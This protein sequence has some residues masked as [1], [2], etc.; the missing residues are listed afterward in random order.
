MSIR[1]NQKTDY[2]QLFASVGGNGS[3]NNSINFG[4]NLSDYASIKSGSY[5]K[6]MKAYYKKVDSSDIKAGDS[7]SSSIVK[8]SDKYKDDVVSAYNK[9]S[10]SAEALSDSLDK[11]V[12][13][14]S[15]SVFTKKNVESTDEKGNTETKYGYDVESIYSAVKDMAS[16]YNNFIDQAKSSTDDNIARQANNLATTVTLS[17]SK[18]NAIGITI[19]DD[20]KLS[21][22]E[23]KFRKADMNAVKNLFNGNQS[24]GYQ[25]A[26]KAS[27]IGT[28]ASSEAKAASGYT[29]TASY[30]QT[31]NVNSI[32]NS[33]V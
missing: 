27:M 8:G 31:P 13:K 15:D 29:G 2:S 32:L 24:L 12:S 26:S 20:D 9:I 23:E 19:G 18:L 11:L 4:V 25:I 5:G 1:I 30:A 10:S 7:T 6:L 33:I 14:G 16:K 3:N 22:D 21:I 17:N 28:K